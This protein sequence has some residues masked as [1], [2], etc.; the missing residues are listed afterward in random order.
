ME[1][2]LIL[3]AV[4]NTEAESAVVLSY[5]MNTLYEAFKKEYKDNT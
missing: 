2:G 3:R 5:Y 4:N 1:A